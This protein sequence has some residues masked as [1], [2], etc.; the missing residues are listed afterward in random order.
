MKYSWLRHIIP[1]CLTIMI[2]LGVTAAV[3][4]D[5]VFFVNTSTNELS[6]GLG[7]SY[8][9]G[10]SGTAK[11]AS[12]EV[13]IIT[14]SGLETI[15][16]AAVGAEGGAIANVGKTSISIPYDTVKVGLY[17]YYSSARNTSVETCKVTNYVGS[18]F[19]F[20]YQNSDREFVKLGSTS[21]TS[22]TVM[23]DT[24]VSVSSGT[25]GCFHIK[26]DG[27]YSSFSA[28]QAV[29][30]Q[31]SGGFP[32]YYSG[33]FYV[34]VGNYTSTANAESAMA[35][36]GIEGT[37]YTASSKAITVTKTGTTDVI[38]EFDYGTTQY[39]SIRPISTSGDAITTVAG[40]S[41]SGYR[42][43]GDFTFLRY[44]N[45]DMTV[46]NYVE[47]E[48]YVKG[49][50]P[51][52]MSSSWPVE[53]LKAQALC[54]RT[55]VASNFN[56]YGSVG[57]DVTND[58]YSQVYRGTNS[59]NTTTNSAVDQT[60]GQ[61][62]TYEGKL[63][64]TFFFSSDGGAT[65]NSENVFYTALPYLVG[66]V[67]PYE[68]DVT[69]TYKTWEYS[70]SASEIASKLQSKGH[71]IYSITDFEY[72]KTD[73]DNMKEVIFY[74]AYGNKVSLTRSNLYSALGLPSINYDIEY[75]SSTNKYDFIGGGWGHNI[76]MS[77]WGA[78]SMASVHGFDYADIICFYFTGVDISKG[79]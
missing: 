46:V 31:Y 24:N 23:S 9:I 5:N 14:G 48:D 76:G 61:Y 51:Y 30:N 58:T 15:N 26:L 60:A 3:S 44:N 53:A 55:Y 8:A 40:E 78:Y 17:Y 70:Y 34:L 52:E 41:D 29:A 11:L 45:E 42:Y 47:M 62:V 74:D 77:Q 72:E 56:M 13:T 75:N 69:F 73:V 57:F 19:E 25:V 20:G 1:C 38:F 49:V 63:C 35:S 36:R 22:L 18:G 71:T 65:E 2:L 68:E 59:A 39:L 79:V 21:E 66:I 32:A 37:V 10:S 33:K 4:A 7:E 16:S 27:S 50:I 43:Y 67:D 6:Q 54:A 28:A 12:G 64:S